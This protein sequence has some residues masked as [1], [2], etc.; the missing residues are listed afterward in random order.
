MYYALC[1]YFYASTGYQRQRL[2]R[3]HYF[4]LSQCPIIPCQ[5][6]L[7]C[8]TDESITHML[9]HRHHTMTVHNLKLRVVND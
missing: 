5:H 8:K 2:L 3:Y 6:G 4:L 1:M 7:L 9:Q